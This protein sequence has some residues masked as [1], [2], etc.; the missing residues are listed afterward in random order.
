MADAGDRLPLGGGHGGVEGTGGAEEQIF[1][2]PLRQPREEIAGEHRGGAAAAR[3][4]A[5][6]VLALGVKEETAAVGVVLQHDAPAL[7]KL[8]KELAAQPPQVP[9]DDQVIEVGAAASVLKVGGDGVAGG[10]G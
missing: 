1:P 7:Q 2:P 5:V 3:A 4:A 8:Q 6:D 10:G 9:G